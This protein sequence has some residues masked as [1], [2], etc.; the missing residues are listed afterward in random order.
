VTLERIVAVH[1]HVVDALALISE[2]TTL[3]ELDQDRLLSQSCAV[4]CDLL[5]DWLASAWWD[6]MR[7]ASDGP[8]GDLDPDQGHFPKLLD[9][10]LKD[11]LAWAD[12]HG[13]SVSAARTDEARA[14]VTATVRRHPRMR[15]QELFQVAEMRVGDLQREICALADQLRHRPQAA[16]AS[17]MP[18]RA[19]RRRAR[20]ALAMGSELLVALVP[21]IAGAGRGQVA[22]NLSEWGHEDA[23]VIT[24]LDIAHRAQPSQEIVPARAGLFWD[25]LGGVVVSESRTSQDYDYEEHFNRPTSEMRDEEVSAGERYRSGSGEEAPRTPGG[26]GRGTVAASDVSRARRQY[27]KGECPESI[28]VCESFSLLASIV[29][30]GPANAGLKPLRCR[31]KDGMY[32]WSSTLQG[33]GFLAVSA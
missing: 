13:M 28:P 15:R 8:I 7:P 20:T 5:E 10:V 31:R 9:S 4:T 32:S 19:S 30:A 1:R 2:S 21:A 33:C 12:R 14:A 25:A 16:A 24:V 3:S 29:L 11:A 6:G 22:Q 26:P 23:K 17:A 18:D 27:L